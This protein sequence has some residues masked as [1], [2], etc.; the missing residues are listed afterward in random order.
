MLQ[1][2]CVLR[3]CT[4]LSVLT[5]C[6]SQSGVEWGLCL[7][8]VLSIPCPFSLSSRH[9]PLVRAVA[10][11]N[12]A[13]RPLKIWN[14]IQDYLSSYLHWSA[15]LAASQ[16]QWFPWGQLLRSKRQK[17]AVCS[18]T[19]CLSPVQSGKPAGNGGT[20]AL[21]LSSCLSLCTLPC[22]GT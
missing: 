3:I 21:G 18:N 12:H 1:N 20:Q 16:M 6:V 10:L 9:H 5:V 17:P 22:L 7:G 2:L 4:S 19:P 14:F 8:L 15:I 11:P 13:N